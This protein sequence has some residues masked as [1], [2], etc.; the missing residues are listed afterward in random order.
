MTT[1][2]LSREEFAASSTAALSRLRQ[3]SQQR[4]ALSTRAI[5]AGRCEQ[6][7]LRSEVREQGQ[8]NG[9]AYGFSSSEF[10]QLELQDG[11]WLAV[12]ASTRQR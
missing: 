6:L 11:Q 3:F 7:S 8:Q 10:Y 2:Q 12:R 1:M 4:L 9:Q 5:Q